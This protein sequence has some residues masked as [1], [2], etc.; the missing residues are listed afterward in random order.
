[1]LPI[2]V[3]LSLAFGRFPENN[4]NRATTEGHKIAHIGL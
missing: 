4:I 2:R 3:Q 1:M